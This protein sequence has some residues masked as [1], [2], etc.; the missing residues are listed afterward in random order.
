M[1]NHSYPPTQCQ[2][3]FS[4][5]ITLACKQWVTAD[6][7]INGFL[8][9]FSC[10]SLLH[11][12]VKWGLKMWLICKDFS[13]HYMFYLI[14]AMPIGIALGNALCNMNFF[15]WRI[16]SLCVEL[17]D[18]YNDKKFGCFYFCWQTWENP[19]YVMFSHSYSLLKKLFL[20]FLYFN[21][22]WFQAFFDS[23]TMPPSPHRLG[24]Y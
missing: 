15:L 8:E 11:Y 21:H 9:W 23:L 10:M 6:V 4:A 13:V 20:T 17:L 24:I 18:P 7:C 14:L 22:G 16:L 3:A 12:S 1:V 2:Q 19:Q 5:W